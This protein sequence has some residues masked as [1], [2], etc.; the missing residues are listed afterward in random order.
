LDFFL[1]WI[2]LIFPLP[3]GCRP[4]FNIYAIGA[5]SVGGEQFVESYLICDSTEGKMGKNLYERKH[6]LME[7]N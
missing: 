5:A 7:K 6:S 1:T 2:C 4:G 3:E